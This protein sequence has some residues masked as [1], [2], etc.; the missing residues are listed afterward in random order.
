MANN[1]PPAI[2][3]LDLVGSVKEKTEGETATFKCVVDSYPKS[4]VSWTSNTGK[5]RIDF[6]DLQKNV[7]LYNVTTNCLDTGKYICTA[8]NGIGSPR[9]DT[10][11]EQKNVTELRIEDGQGLNISVRYLAYP[12]AKVTWVFSHQ[13]SSD[14][15]TKHLHHDEDDINI[16]NESYIYWQTSELTKPIMTEDDFG[17]YT[18]TFQNDLSSA[19]SVFYVNAAR[20][21]DPPEFVSSE[22][23]KDLTVNVSWKPGFNGG[24]EQMFVIQYRQSSENNFTNW[25]NKLQDQRIN[26][27]ENVK[28]LTN[29]VE[30]AFRVVAVNSYGE[31]SSDKYSCTTAKL[32]L[33]E[34]PVVLPVIGGTLGTLTGVAAVIILLLF[35]RRRNHTKDIK[36]NDGLFVQYTFKRL[37]FEQLQKLTERDSCEEEDGGMKVNIL[38]EPAGPNIKPEGATGGKKDI[39][40]EV[41]KTN[42]TDNTSGDIYA[43]VHKRAEK[44]KEDSNKPSDL[45]AVVQKPITKEHAEKNKKRFGKAKQEKLKKGNIYENVEKL[46]AENGAYGVSGTDEFLPGPSGTKSPGKPPKPEK[47]PKRKTIKAT[48]T[49]VLPTTITIKIHVFS[50]KEDKY[51]D[52]KNRLIYAELVLEEGTKDGNRFVIRGEGDRTQYVEIDFSKRAKPLPPDNEESEFKSPAEVTT[53]EVGKP[54]IESTQ[55]KEVIW[56]YIV[57]NNKNKCTCNDDHE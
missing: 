24:S 44:S 40:S 30:Y 33:T 57:S 27:T 29:G 48:F 14:N 6:I 26:I 31:T 35:L 41:K 10:R 54:K 53:S 5:R 56:A 20:A 36:P 38:Y 51:S 45:S 43:Q 23:L 25:T 52:N 19:S 8:S 21:P 15:T 34:P 32:I 17:T 3:S 18:V 42:R 55:Q 50:Q 11:Y 12:I 37:S 1:D 9:I 16:V 4:N 13:N 28:G 46:N 39:Y 49:R 22:C 7:S 47:P 2:S